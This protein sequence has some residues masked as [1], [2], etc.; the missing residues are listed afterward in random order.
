MS[1]SS[2]QTT[3]EKYRVL[4]DI[5]NA[6]ITNRDR[7]SLFEDVTEALR[8]ILPFDRANIMLYLREEDGFRPFVRSGPKVVP[9]QYSGGRNGAPL[10]GTHPSGGGFQTGASGDINGRWDRCQCVAAQRDRDRERIDCPHD[11][12]PQPEKRQNPGESNLRL[13]ARQSD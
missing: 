1:K 4:L 3:E 12:S 7:E 2:H 8:S 9:E 11:P 10:R 5:N 13:S 6:I